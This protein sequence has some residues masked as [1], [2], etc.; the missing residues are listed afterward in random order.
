[1]SR[2]RG[3]AQHDRYHR[4][5]TA[6]RAPDS[7]TTTPGAS[8]SP[9]ACRCRGGH[10]AG[11][12]RCCALLSGVLSLPEVVAEGLLACMPGALFSAVL[13][14]LQHAAKPLFYRLG[15]H[16][17]VDR[18]R[19]PGA[20]VRRPSR[21]G[22]RPSRSSSAPGWCSALGVYTVL[23]RGHF[24][25]APA[26][27]ADLARAVAAGGVRRLR[28][29]AVRDLRRARR[30]RAMPRMIAPDWQPAR[31]CCATR[32]R[33]RGG[34]RSGGH[35]VALHVVGRRSAGRQCSLAGA[36][37]RAA[38]RRPNPPPF[39]LKGMS[40]RSRRPTDF[41]TVSKNFIDPSGC[42]QRLAVEDRRP[43]RPPDGADVR[44]SSPRCRPARAITR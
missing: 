11:D 20:L 19:L 32:R 28:R 8:V 27:R 3:R 13:D 42:R 22:N 14:S 24:R 2:Y 18:G 10:A 38:T 37:G 5:P 23:G 43:G 4:S 6:R 40:S 9:P 41:Y 15:W 31:R 25:P 21:A 33:G 34:R 44:R 35:R 17:H 36:G 29:G 26:G 7:P 16:R 30:R 39:D 1:M 12:R